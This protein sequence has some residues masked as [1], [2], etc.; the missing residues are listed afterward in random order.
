MMNTL[1]QYTEDLEHMF[2]LLNNLLEKTTEDDRFITMFYG[3]IDLDR[4]TMEYVNAGHDAP[5]IYRAAK[6]V[7]EELQ[8][9]GML[10]GVLPSERFRLGDTAR[11]NSGD[12]LLLTTDGIWEAADPEGGAFGKTRV[13]DILRE[14]Q[15]QPCQAILDALFRR[16]KEHC[17]GQRAADDQTAV[18]FKFR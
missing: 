17:A 2:F 18:L 3:L 9:T 8:S 13:F 12:L 16:V 15:D 11:F 1:E 6:G 5:I 10:L 4:K 14:M 7:F